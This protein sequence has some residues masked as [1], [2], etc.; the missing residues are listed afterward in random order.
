MSQRAFI[1]PV[2]SRYDEVDAVS[3]FPTSQSACLGPKRHRGSICDKPV[4]V[5]VGSRIWV[6]GGSCPPSS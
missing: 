1:Q 4:R 2:T 3:G 5:A 6:K